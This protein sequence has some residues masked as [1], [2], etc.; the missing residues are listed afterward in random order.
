MANLTDLKELLFNR[1]KSISSINSYWA[2]LINSDPYLK[3][4][5]TT[6]DLVFGNGK[7]VSFS[8]N[9]LECSDDNDNKYIYEPFLQEEITISSS[10]KFGGGQASQRVLSLSIDGRKVDALSIILNGDFLSGIGEICIQNNNGDFESRY[11]ILRGEM[12]GSINFGVKDE[13]IQLEVGDPDLRINK[14]IPEFLITKED[15]YALPDNNTGLRFPV[16][17]DNCYAGVSTIRTSEYEWGPTFIIAYGHDITVI[18]VYLNGILVPNNDQA[19]GWEILYEITD[20]GIPYTAIDFVFANGQIIT[21]NMSN[22]LP[23]STSVDIPPWDNSDSVYVRT[24]SKSGKNRSII[25]LIRNLLRN[26]IVYGANLID[27]KLFGKSEGKVPFLFGQVIINGSSSST[28]TTALEYVESAI[29]PSFPMIS[30]VYSGSG[31]GCVVTD[32]RSNVFFGTFIVGQELIFDRITGIQETPKEEIYNSFTLRYGYNSLSDTY[33]KS[34]TRNKSNSYVCEISENRTGKRD[35]DQ[36]DSILIFDDS[37][38][39]YV[40]E[41]LSAHFSLPSY[42][43]EYL[44]IPS[45]FFKLNLGDNIKITDNEL[46]FIEEVGTIEKL[47]YTK[48]SLTIGIRFWIL[49]TKLTNSH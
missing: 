4:S 15:F 16:V 39:N 22:G 20:S 37:T 9:N 7:K 48:G 35:Y 32:R 28:V 27:E 5:F 1:I 31:I 24:E 45:L 18:E 38:A 13:L 21:Q 25:D 8:T 26:N 30:M 12:R 23:F 6:I 29:C 49:Y 34:V 11:V 41:W 46:G 14:T 2:T 19:R 10:Y 36:I 44:A 40:I 33:E 17:F 47:E 3:E 43:I 42:Y